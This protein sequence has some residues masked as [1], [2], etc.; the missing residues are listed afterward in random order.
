MLR[1]GLVLNG[2]DFEKSLGKGRS[3]RAGGRQNAT[4][5][6]FAGGQGQAGLHKAADGN[7]VA[8]V[9]RPIPTVD[10]EW[11]FKGTRKES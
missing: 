11:L 3:Q 6:G 8:G 10:G 9:A 5:F 7:E 1:K 2:A 4:C